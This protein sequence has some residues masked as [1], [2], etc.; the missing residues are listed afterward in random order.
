ME[1]LTARRLTLLVV[2]LVPVVA[3]WIHVPA[4]LVRSAA[5]ES[6]SAREYREC[7]QRT[8]PT[9]F[10][11]SCDNGSMS[12]HSGPDVTRQSF[13]VGWG[14]LIRRIVADDR[15]VVL[16]VPERATSTSRSESRGRD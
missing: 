4:G 7:T 16:M 15:A 14:H 1:R 5:T 3:F 8:P 12:P 11:E 9:P 10:M 6:E 2:F 13:F